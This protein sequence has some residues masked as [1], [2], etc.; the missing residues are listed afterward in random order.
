MEETDPFLNTNPFAELD[1]YDDEQLSPTQQALSPSAT[2]QQPLSANELELEAI[3]AQQRALL[4]ATSTFTANPAEPSTNASPTMSGV[5][6]ASYDA[7]NPTGYL[8]QSEEKEESP[9]EQQPEAKAFADGQSSSGFDSGAD[10]TP[11]VV[12]PTQDL[13]N[14][15]QAIQNQHRQLQSEMGDELRKLQAELS[16]IKKH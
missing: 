9:P 3:R 15:L 5:P 10:P 12:Q 14:F 6:T 7:S 8:Q 13:S 2:P 1:G 16:A 4:Q 11:G